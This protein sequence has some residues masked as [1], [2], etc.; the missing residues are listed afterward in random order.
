MLIGK[1]QPWF[2]SLAISLLAGVTVVAAEPAAQFRPRKPAVTP[3]LQVASQPAAEAAPKVV[4]PGKLKV[5]QGGQPQ[6]QPKFVL[7]K[8]LAQKLKPAKPASPKDLVADLKP[9]KPGFPKDIAPLPKP[10]KP[11]NPD[12]IAPKP[13]DQFPGPD[14]KA[15]PQDNPGPQDEEQ[16]EE[17]GQGNG[18]GNGN[19]QNGNNQEWKEWLYWLAWLGHNHHNHGPVFV[20]PELPVIIVPQVPQIVVPLPQ[21]PAIKRYEVAIGSDLPLGGVNFGPETGHAILQVGELVV[22][23]TT[24]DWTVETIVVRLP[25]LG[26]LG[27]ANADLHLYNAN[28][29]L[30][31]TVPLKLMPA[32]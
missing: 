16:P 10:P 18:N 11:W 15:P 31:S 22:A 4:L 13:K 5:P 26:L 12:K 27:S 9:M 3:D 25:E 17:N 32:E 28:G 8:D 30:L 14:D 6:Q 21:Q 20:E 19:G 24:P 2:S 23:L 7:P 29:D 1:F